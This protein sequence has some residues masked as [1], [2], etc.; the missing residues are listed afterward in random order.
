M[1]ILYIK[2]TSELLIH[3]LPKVQLRLRKIGLQ[4][5]SKALSAV[6]PENLMK[7]SIRIE[8]N[9]LSIEND[10]YNLKKY[11]NI[12][13]IGGGKATAEMALTLEKILLKAKVM[14]YN[15]IINVPEASK[16]Q[17]NFKKSKI[18]INFASHP[19]PNKNGFKGTSSMMEIV[20]NSNKNDLII[21]LISGGGSALLPFPKKG[22]NLNDLQEVNS[23]L[24]SSG[25]PI[26][27][28]NIIRKHLSNFKGG[29]LA[30]KL[31]NSS[32]AT[33]ISL[34]ISDVV[35][36][37]LDAIASGPTVPDKSTFEDAFEI[38][39]KYSLW[40]KIPISVKEHLE[41]G[42]LDKSL[43]N[44]KPEDICFKNV[45]NYLIGSVRYAAQEVKAFLSM[46]GFEV[47]YFSNNI[48]GEAKEFGKSLY[49]IISNYLQKNSDMNKDVRK[50]LVGT[51]EL[52]V[53]I[54]GNGIG[55]RNQEMLLSYLKILKKRKPDYN[56]LI[57]SVNLDGLE[58][59]SEAMGALI[60][61][62]SFD[63][64]ISNKINPEEF[65]ENNDS[66]S[67][68]KKLRT[69]I[70]SGPTGCNVNDLILVLI[71]K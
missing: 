16:N 12:Y 22:I 47:D 41:K 34:I 30:K 61:N 64:M 59:N 68:F 29:N 15:G 9:K 46:E 57:I 53:T 35:G 52:T 60:D 71:S 7:K 42:L 33:L 54:R 20:E 63:H 62:Y 18:S 2:N 17:V 51:G 24:L 55:G 58:G 37:D 38:I 50:A 43:E 14:H 27:E 11:E 13:L 44:P 19:I 65:L 4:A 32:G 67:F 6:K 5:I 21:C 25:V 66:N 56:F 23:L 48:I 31:H 39:N 1:L 10:E 26:H 40:K 36:D 69:E 3:K 70:I 8:N 28:I 45:H 49:N